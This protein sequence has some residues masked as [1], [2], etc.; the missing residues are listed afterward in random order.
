MLVTCPSGLSFYVRPWNL[1]DNAALLDSVR[2]DYYGAMTPL[3]QLA[4]ISTPEPRMLVVKPFDRSS[5]SNVE[6]AISNLRDAGVLEPIALH[7]LS[8]EKLG[9]TG[10]G[11]GIGIPHGKSK[12]VSELVA[13][14]GLSKKDT[15]QAVEKGIKNLTEIFN[16]N[17]SEFK[18]NVTK[19]K[20]RFDIGK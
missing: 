10:I 18:E 6:K 8:R 1:G 4:T 2:V 13:A 15:Q 3:N 7:V 17:A 9:S 19:F 20:K 12:N 16:K 5:A 11:Q 14:F